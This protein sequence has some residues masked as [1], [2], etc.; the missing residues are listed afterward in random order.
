[1]SSVRNTFN[2]RQFLDESGREPSSHLKGSLCGEMAGV[3]LQ[4]NVTFRKFVAT[5]LAAN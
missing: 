2:T 4:G 3:E 5:A 1:M